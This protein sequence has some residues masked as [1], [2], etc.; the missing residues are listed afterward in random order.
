MMYWTTEFR[1]SVNLTP[2]PLG[3]GVDMADAA[4]DHMR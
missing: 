3:D 1:L 2:N 4:M